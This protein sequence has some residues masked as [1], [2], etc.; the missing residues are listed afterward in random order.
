MLDKKCKRITYMVTYSLHVINKPS[1]FLNPTSRL[2]NRSITFCLIIFIITW[3]FAYIF[4]ND[5]GLCQ[6]GASIYCGKINR[7]LLTCL[8]MKKHVSGRQNEIETWK[9]VNAKLYSN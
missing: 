2:P 6:G 1:G 4:S 3:D 7:V 8:G 5:L 9:I